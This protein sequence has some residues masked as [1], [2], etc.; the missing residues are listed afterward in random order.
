MKKILIATVFTIKCFASFHTIN[1][2]EADFTQK[3]I[4]DNNK[5][6]VYKGHIQ[7]SKPQFALWKYTN[8]IQKQIYIMDN[9]VIIIEPELEQAIYKKMDA[10]FN[11][12]TMINN[13]KKI[14][15]NVYEARFREKR[16]F[17]VTDDNTI[18][19][20]TYHDDFDNKIIIE[21]KNE[22]IN[23]K[24]P[25]EVFEAVIPNDFDVIRE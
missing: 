23:R 10:S 5:T 22:V 19:S 18:K 9:R 11:F 3:I 14:T 7:A 16:F 15:K 13:A 2:F 17:I 25:Q 21:F 24:I 4:D 12:F 6:I 1:Q 8:P 20:I